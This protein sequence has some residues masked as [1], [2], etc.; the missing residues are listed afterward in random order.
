MHVK[1]KQLH[2]QAGITLVEVMVVVAII[3][4]MAFFAGPEMLQFGPKAKLKA[5]TQTLKSNLELA[6]LEAVKR[7]T[8]VTV[9]FTTS[10]CNTFPLVTPSEY[11]ITWMDGA[12]KQ[13]IPLM[14]SSTSS[15]SSK[16]TYEF[17][18]GTALC[19]SDTTIDFTSRG[20]ASAQKT[21]K[22]ESQEKDTG[23]PLY[24]IDV[25]LGGAISV[26]R[27]EH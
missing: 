11:E 16:D 7:N 8:T 22:L 25:S 1:Q 14:A 17:P 12:T 26:E 20:Y 18:E 9:T 23:D 4:V 6:R 19:G 2:S 3:V 13:K 24:E 21:L 10:G 15:A 5:A 27:K